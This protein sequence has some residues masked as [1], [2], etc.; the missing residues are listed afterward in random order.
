MGLEVKI[1][2]TG[3]RGTFILI[4]LSIVGSRR[5]QTVPLVLAEQRKGFIGTAM[6]REERRKKQ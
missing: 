2:K 6:S 1:S 4:K 5:R 3:L